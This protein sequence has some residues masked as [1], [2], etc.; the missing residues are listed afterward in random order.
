MAIF[1][2]P[3]SS[4]YLDFPTIVQNPRGPNGITDVDCN[5]LVR[6]GIMWHR[7]VF[8]AEGRIIRAACLQNEIA[9]EKCLNRYEKRVEIRDKGSE[10]RSETGPNIFQPVSGRLKIFHRHFS[11]SFSP[12]KICTQKRFFSPRGSAGVAMQRNKGGKHLRLRSELPYTVWVA[13]L[14]N[15][16]ALEC[17]QFQNKSKRKMKQKVRKTP[18]VVPEK[19]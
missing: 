19:V 2:W 12:P 18:R 8:V 6:C 14:Q 16:I 11:K 13:P 9:P 1:Q 17:F 4:Y 7:T 10:K 3:Y 15:E 5:F